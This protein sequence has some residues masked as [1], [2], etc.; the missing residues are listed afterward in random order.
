MCTRPLCQCKPH[1]PSPLCS[2]EEQRE[3][4]VKKQL[5]EMISDQIKHPINPASV[6]ILFLNLNPK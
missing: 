3:I 5:S 4:K 6:L 1:L 2:C